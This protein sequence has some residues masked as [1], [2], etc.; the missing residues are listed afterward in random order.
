ML[1]SD[2]G[3]FFCVLIAAVDTGYRE[4]LRQVNIV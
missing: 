4:L 3:P 1:H 2:L